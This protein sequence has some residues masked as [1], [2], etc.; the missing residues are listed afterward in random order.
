MPLAPNHHV[1][2]DRMKD[3]KPP[4][5]G[6]LWRPGSSPQ[7]NPLHITVAIVTGLIVIGVVVLAI[8]T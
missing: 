1:Q 2:G 7:D 3:D 5:P 4:P 8:L 6:Y